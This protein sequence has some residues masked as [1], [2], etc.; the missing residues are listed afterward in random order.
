MRGI[1]EAWFPAGRMR[2]AED[3]FGVRFDD[4]TTEE[5]IRLAEYHRCSR[6]EI[7]RALVNRSL[8]ALASPSRVA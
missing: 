1:P 3:G 7:V 5:I 6:A 8:I 2:L 4:K